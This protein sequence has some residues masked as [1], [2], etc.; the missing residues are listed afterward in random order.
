MNYRKLGKS[1]LAVSEIGFGAWGIGGPAKAGSTPVGWADWDLA[2][3]KRAI[4]RSVELGITFFDTADFY[5]FG[6]SEELLGEVLGGRWK[7]LVV[8]TKVGHVLAPDGS[9][10]LNYTRPHI[11]DACEQSLRRLRKDVIDVYQLHSAKLEHLERGE[12]IE[13]M[14]ELKR[15]GKI[16]AWGISL[17]TFAP[18]REGPWMLDHNAG[19]TFQLA[20]NI[21]NQKALEQI[22]PRAH[23]LG[24]G[25]IARM[26]LQFGLLTGKFSDSTRFDPADHR[27]MRLPPEILARGNRLVGQL[28]PIAGT[29][30]ISLSALALKFVLA[31]D[32]VSTVIPGIKNVEQAELNASASEEPQLSAEDFATLHALYESEFRQFLDHLRQAG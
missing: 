24:Y 32:S 6:R 16:R 23:K 19:D 29:M 8:A 10:Q 17:N 9:I 28:A 26:P 18:E 3:S 5:G 30:N 22:I 31:H 27:S 15:Q 20:L 21:L 13:A 7:D 14:E 25:I 12:C 1:G 2:A 11:I 4:E